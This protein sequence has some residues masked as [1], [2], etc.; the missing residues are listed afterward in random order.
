MN[1][2]ILISVLVFIVII[3][4][5]QLWFANKSRN[6][7]YDLSEDIYREIESLDKELKEIKEQTSSNNNLL[8]TYNKVITDKSEELKSYK[9]ASTNTKQKGLFTSLIGI[10][11]FIEKFNLDNNHLDEK[12]KDYLIAIQDKLEIAL[13][14]T[15]IEKFEPNLNEN[16]MEVIGCTPS[17]ITKKTTDS[18]KINLISLVIKPGY[19][20]L[21][22]NDKFNYIKNA[23]VEIF[24]LEKK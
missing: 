22:R 1:T 2:T 7:N 11:D 23:E 9:E 21:I 10:I 3:L 19:R 24:E 15:G 12:T 6:E 4:I 20:I 17:K 5:V 16:I 8:E 13:S 14:S 18:N